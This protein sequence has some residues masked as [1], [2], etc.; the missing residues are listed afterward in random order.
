VKTPSAGDVFTAYELGNALMALF[1]HVKVRYLRRGV[2]WYSPEYLSDVDVLITLLDQYD[3][4]RTLSLFQD[5]TPPA[6][7]K[8]LEFQCIQKLQIKPNLISIAWVRN[9]FHRWLTKPWFGN[10]D[11]V[12]TS[13]SLTKSFYDTIGSKIGF[14]VSCALSCPHKVPGFAMKRLT[15]KYLASKNSS[16]I[17]SDDQSWYLFPTRA[18][19]P[20][21]VFPIATAIV[22]PDNNGS[23]SR[24]SSPKSKPYPLP[25]KTGIARYNQSNSMTSEARRIFRGVDYI[26]TG[27][28]FNVPRR[29]MDFDPDSIPEWNG[30]IVG[31]NWEKVRRNLTAGWMAITLGFL[32]YE[33]VKEV[34]FSVSPIFLY[35]LIDCNLSFCIF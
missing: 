33:L 4:T 20:V 6:Y 7:P 21:Y 19:T 23:I 34:S 13:S 8:N 30:R 32:P 3:L 17:N 10:Y 9:W 29:I 12:L 35:L 11:A 28:Y 31:G 22:E 18:E 2:Q 24:G 25:S 5:P 27:S 16:G 1:S 15:E 14:P 26:F